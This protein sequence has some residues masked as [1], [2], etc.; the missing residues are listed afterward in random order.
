MKT[1]AP[2]L[3]ITALLLHG[4]AFFGIWTAPGLEDLPT[5]ETLQ[6][7]EEKEER[8]SIERAIIPLT[9]TEEVFIGGV[10]VQ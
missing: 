10:K 1:A 8:S 4:T 9:A 2:L 5:L 7:E 6:G 3:I